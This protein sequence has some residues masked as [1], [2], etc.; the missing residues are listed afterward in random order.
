GYDNNF[1]D[2]L[3]VERNM[4]RTATRTQDSREAMRAFFQKRP[5]NFTGN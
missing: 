1:N 3:W 5:P 2:Q 4:Q